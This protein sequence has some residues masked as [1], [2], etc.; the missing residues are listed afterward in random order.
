[1]IPNVVRGERMA[2]L[3]VYLVGEGR[4]NE[5]TEPHLVAGDAALMAWHADAELNRDSAA[6]IARHLDRPRRAFDTEVSGGHVWHCSL[7]LRAEEGMLTDEKWGAIASDFIRLMGFD[8]AEG[9]KA[10]VRWVAVRHGLSQNGN[11]HIHVAVNLVREDGTKASVHNDFRRA[12]NAARVLEAEHGLERLESLAA[13]RA[14]R[15]WEPAEREAQARARAQAEYTRTKAHGAPDWEHLPAADRQGKVVAQLRA[16]QP[17]HAL[18]RTVRACATASQDEAE[19]VRRLRRSGVIVRP[20]Y[21]DGTRDVITGY[22]VAERPRHGERPIWYGGGHLGRDLTLP[23]LRAE[24]PD[25]PQGAMDAA[26]EWN[27]ARRARG[28]VA[29]GREAHEPDPAMWERMDTELGALREHLRNVPLEDRDTWA[30]VARDTAGAFAA[31]SKAVE[32]TPGELAAAADALSRSAQTF[33]RHQAPKPLFMA[34]L[35]GTAMLLASAKKGGRGPIGQVALLRQLLALAQA[36]HDV[37]H[38]TDQLRQATAIRDTAYTGLKDIHSRLS[39]NAKAT[40]KHGPEA[41]GTAVATAPPELTPE[42]EQMRQMLA[43]TR[44]PAPGSVVP[45]RIEPRTDGAAAAPR[46]NQPRRGR[47]RDTGAER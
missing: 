10:P 8:D 13:E 6:A 17:R 38:A 26:A 15:G 29:P 47:G 45:N 23:R 11:D 4:H 32:Q 39:A 3:M 27:A 20:R 7:S 34:P 14:T 19:F 22:S 9:T 2:G 28:V 16:E 40:A 18:A 24:W 1:M 46:R 42:L 30:R 31:W 12:Q 43:A 36:I 25:T 33:Q 41:A 21:A 37:A 35:A 44:P 5:H